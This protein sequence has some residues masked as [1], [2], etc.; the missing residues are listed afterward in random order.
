MVTDIFTPH[1]RTALLGKEVSV[2]KLQTR[3]K[4][5]GS[6]GCGI[7]HDL[8]RDLWPA[9]LFGQQTDNRGH[10]AACA[11]ADNGDLAGIKTNLV[12]MLRDPLGGG[13]SFLI[14]NRVVD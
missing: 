12:A 8:R 5:T 14:R 10:V 11:V 9:A 13:V 3:G 7:K 4:I 1:P 6:A 2:R